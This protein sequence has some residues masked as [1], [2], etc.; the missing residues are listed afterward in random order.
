MES[1]FLVMLLQNRGLLTVY[2]LLFILVKPALQKQSLCPNV[3]FKLK[4]NT[5]C[6]PKSLF[7]ESQRVECSL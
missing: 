3:L 1:L 2:F 6:T 4:A 5:L 7:C